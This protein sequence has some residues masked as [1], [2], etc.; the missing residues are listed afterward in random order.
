DPASFALVE[1]FVSGR[2]YAVELF[3]DGETIHFTSIW[4]FDFGRNAFDVIAFERATMVTDPGELAALAPLI[5]HAIAV[6]HA[7]DVEWGPLLVEVRDDPGRGPSLIE[8]GARLTG[9]DL[10]MLIKE[11]SNF[12]PFEATLSIYVGRETF[13]MPAVRFSKTGTLV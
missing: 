2:Q 5:G 6:G 12:D 13:V 4:A 7:V 8:V 11:S 1:G 3:A 10:P 9:I